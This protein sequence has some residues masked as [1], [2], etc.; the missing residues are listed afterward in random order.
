MDAQ[1]TD[2]QA[3]LLEHAK[4]QTKALETLTNIAWAWSVVFVLVALWAFAA[5]R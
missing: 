1:N 5:S 2:A 4:R 3:A